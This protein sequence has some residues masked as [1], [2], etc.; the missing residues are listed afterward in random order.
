MTESACSGTVISSSV[1]PGH[2]MN[3]SFPVTTMAA[4]SMAASGLNGMGHPTSPPLP[5]KWGLDR[6]RP[7]GCKIMV[8]LAEGD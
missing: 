6:L 7:A 4:D 2:S 1:H 5:F 8:G 3:I